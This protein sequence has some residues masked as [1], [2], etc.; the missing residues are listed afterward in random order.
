V[1]IDHGSEERFCDC[2]EL[3][4]H[5]ERQPCPPFHDCDYVRKR[6]ALI[7]EAE[8]IVNAKVKIVPASEDHGESGALWTK[9]FVL[10]MDALAEP[11]LNGADA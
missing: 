4:L 10:C 5:G 1:N 9:A 7:P 3:L 11:L 2:Q 8:K 6:S